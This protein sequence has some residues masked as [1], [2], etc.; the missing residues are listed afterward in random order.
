MQ[1]Y[2][3]NPAGGGFLRA[4]IEQELS[5]AST[6][7]RR[8]LFVCTANQQR[9]PTAEALFRD[10]PRIEARSCGTDLCAM[11]PC[12]DE[13][14]E[15]AD[16]IFCMEEGHREALLTLFPSAK[17]KSIHVLHVPDIYLRNDRGLIPILRERL[18]PWL[19]GR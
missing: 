14:I 17:Q 18:H 15:W 12:D 2:R 4:N 5:A 10:H 7:K 11:T 9:S 8:L 3:G 16:E 19:G 6:R 1:K 13:Q